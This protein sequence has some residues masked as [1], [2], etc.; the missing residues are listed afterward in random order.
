MAIRKRGNKWIYDIYDSNNKRLRGI[1]KIEGLACEAVTRKQALEYEKI[2]KGKVA[3]GL[4]LASNQ[5]DI[6]IERLVKVYLD[7]CEVN[8]ARPD[9]DRISCQHL[10]KFF[11]GYKSSKISLWI[12]ERY[13]KER[14]EAGVKARTINIELASLRQMFNKAIEWKLIKNNPIAGMKLLK[15]VVR[16]VKVIEGWEFQRLYGAANDNFKSIL[17]FAYFTGCRRSE[18]R[19]LKWVNVNLQSSYVVIVDTKNSEE[20]TIDGFS[21][22]A[23]FLHRR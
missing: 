21:Q 20:R 16:E 2:L 8:H 9:R 7:W 14:K 11:K 4:D 5:K 12:V 17:L 3:E 23:T 19:N 1:V 15:Q 13:K 6:S 22:E 18:I 10:L